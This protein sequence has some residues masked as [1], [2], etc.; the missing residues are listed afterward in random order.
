MTADGAAS[1]P[2]G[3]HH[4]GDP[5]PDEA[6]QIA[7]GVA[8]AVAP[9]DG[10]EPIQISLLGSV[11]TALIGSPVDFVALEPLD[12]AGLAAALASRPIVFR[13]RVVHQMVLGE[14]ILR[15]IPPEV[16]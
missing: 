9:P 5:A 3:R 11:H 6:L 8:T 7:R 14:L 16:A 15:P 10:L 12:P 4:D 13:H 2:A 1:S